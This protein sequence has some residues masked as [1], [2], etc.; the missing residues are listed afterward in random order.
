[1][2]VLSEADLVS[3]PWIAKIKLREY[4]KYTYTDSVIFYRIIGQDLH[5]AWV[6]SLTADMQ[7]RIPTTT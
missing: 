1:M 3:Q 6:A 7:A 5:G 2:T 4:A